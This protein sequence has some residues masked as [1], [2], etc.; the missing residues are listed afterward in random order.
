MG[1]DIKKTKSYQDIYVQKER[2][3]PKYYRATIKRGTR[4][5]IFEDSAPEALPRRRRKR[6]NGFS[7]KSEKQGSFF[8]LYKRSGHSQKDKKSRRAGQKIERHTQAAFRR[9]M[10]D[11]ES[12]EPNYS[13][14]DEPGSNAY[15]ATAFEEAT[16]TGAASA[17]NLLKKILKA[18]VGTAGASLFPVIVS[19]VIIFTI[20]ASV[21]TVLSSGND[22]DPIISSAG[23]P[24]IVMV[25]AAQLN[26]PKERFTSWYGMDAAWCCM[27]VSWCL[28]QAGYIESGA[29]IK[30]ASSTVQKN[31]LA[32]KDAYITDDSY[33]PQPGNIVF[34]RWNREQNPNIVNH[35]GIVSDVDD[36][37]IYVIHGN[38]GCDYV[39]QTTFRRTSINIAGYGVLPPS[40]ADLSA[41]E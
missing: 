2:T 13:A 12:A 11:I 22:S 14:S 19:A 38:F 35:I 40:D 41:D 26:A 1:D 30:T 7:E 31:Y 6:K 8:G 34:F 37:Y 24:D 17:G 18:V 10:R 36:T 4:H 27:F 20:L 3:A 21:F 32:S 5:R 28:D 25:A 16:I 15:A 33:V 39:R 23:N 9:T 29:A